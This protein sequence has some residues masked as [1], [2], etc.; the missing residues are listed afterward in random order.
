MNILPIVFS[1]FTLL[2]DISKI[3]PEEK[4]FLY[5]PLNFPLDPEI[6]NLFPILSQSP[7]RTE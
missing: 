1:V 4:F 2:T 6:E 3:I 7:H 5:P